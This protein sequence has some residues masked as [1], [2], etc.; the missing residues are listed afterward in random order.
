MTFWKIA[1]NRIS[2]LIS[3]AEIEALGYTLTD[4]TH[5]KERTEEFLNMIL[6]KGEE[7]LGVDMEGEIQ[8]FSGTFLPDGSLLLLISCG[9]REA[10]VE[11]GSAVESQ[12]KKLFPEMPDKGSP[13]LPYQVLFSELD[14]AI[15][16]CSVFGSGRADA[17][18]LYENEEIY[19]LII[20]FQNTEEGRQAAQS[21][22]LAEEFGGM[23]ET[24]AISEQYLQEHEKCLIREH[25]VETLCRMEA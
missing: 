17:S 12:Y 5:N 21:I 24:D 16:F 22:I 3:K 10:A 4:I 1:D 20:E 18:R 9:D 13:I 14:D 19:Y 7:A 23:V 15:R 8:G 25:A 11:S 2:C 6:E